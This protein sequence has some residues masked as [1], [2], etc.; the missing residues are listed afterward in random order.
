MYCTSDDVEIELRES[1]LAMWG[2]ELRNLTPLSPCQDLRVK[3]YRR[4]WEIIDKSE[5][6]IT[7][8]LA[9]PHRGT[10]RVRPIANARM[11]FA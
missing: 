3:V 9:Y 6:I 1:S 7:I 11:T 2:A 10:R 4:D 8:V 5:F